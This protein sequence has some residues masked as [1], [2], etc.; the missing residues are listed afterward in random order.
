MGKP[1]P[2]ARLR[3]VSTGALAAQM[4]LAIARR[5]NTMGITEDSSAAEESEA[6]TD[7]FD[8]DEKP[9]HAS[10][11]PLR[12]L[13]PPANCNAGQTSQDAE[14][15]S[16]A[17]A[18]L[19]AKEE[20]QAEKVEAAVAAAGAKA[21]P[22]VASDSC[23]YAAAPTPPPRRQKSSIARLPVRPP[24][25]PPPTRRLAQPPPPPP[26]RGSRSAS[27]GGASQQD[28]APADAPLQGGSHAAN[29]ERP[30]PAEDASA[31]APVAMAAATATVEKEEEEVIT[32]MASPA[33]TEKSLPQSPLPHSPFNAALARVQAASKAKAIAVE[34]GATVAE[35][36]EVSVSYDA[37]VAQLSEV[38]ESAAFMAKKPYSPPSAT[39]DDPS[40][41]RDDPS[42]TREDPPVTRDDR[43]SPSNVTARSSCEG[44]SQA[45]APGG[46]NGRGSARSSGRRCQVEVATYTPPPTPPP[47]SKAPT[48]KRAMPPSARRHS[49]FH[50]GGSS[51]RI[52]PRT[53]YQAPPSWAVSPSDPG[54]VDAPSSGAKA[55]STV[56]L[57]RWSLPALRSPLLGLPSAWK[58]QMRLMEEA[59]EESAEVVMTQE[60]EGAVITAH[61][62][63]AALSD[64]SERVAAV[65]DR[66]KTKA[67]NHRS[68][69]PMPLCALFAVA[70]AVLLAS[71]YMRP[72]VQASGFSLEPHDYEELPE[73]TRR[74]K[75]LATV[76]SSA[77]SPLATAAAATRASGPGR[78]LYR[79]GRSAAHWAVRRSAIAR[80]IGGGEGVWLATFE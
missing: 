18:T 33:S 29:E 52:S 36:A 62:A 48:S 49:S 40:V 76:A 38:V 59:A 53:V 34:S 17:E 30:L 42:S 56:N 9:Q 66:E 75:A 15:E 44:H 55:E 28:S 63:S 16:A 21:E 10:P 24:F 31:S 72:P 41:T 23:S 71:M 20:E 13:A 1:S 68:V 79:A 25:P 6:S 57:G 58:R 45:S 51:G 46:R 27:S 26:P 47:R 7:D 64:V 74:H 32:E 54:C 37:A 77:L 8:V 12:P 43:S 11:S 67:C 3:V 4:M 60:E 35:V 14:A 5:R 39:R 80:E 61:G 70:L 65:D 69:Q 22:R 2:G 50:G 73:L 19:E 78:L